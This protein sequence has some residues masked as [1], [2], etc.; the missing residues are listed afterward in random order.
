MVQMNAWSP[1]IGTGQEVHLQ[2]LSLVPV[3]PTQRYL[4]RGILYL[5]VENV[6]KQI[7]QALLVKVLLNA[8]SSSIK[9]L[10]A[11]NLMS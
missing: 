8:L 4:I 11:C 6:N 7:S 10:L 3:C 5:S 9:Y 2:F 1:V